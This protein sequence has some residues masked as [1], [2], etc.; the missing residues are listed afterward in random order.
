MVPLNS[1]GAMQ[2]G[3][4]YTGGAWYYLGNDGA[5]RLATEGGNSYYLSSSGAMKTGW[6]GRIT[7][8]RGISKQRGYAEGLAVHWRCLVLSIMTELCRPVGHRKVA[9]AII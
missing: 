1:S 7:A 9:A 4:Q 3:W 8:R 6:L 2:K 5:D